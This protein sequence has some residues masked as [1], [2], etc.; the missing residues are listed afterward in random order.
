MKLT[1]LIENTCHPRYA[2]LGLQAEHGLSLL[3]EDSSGR[4]LLDTGATGAFLENARKLGVDLTRLDGVIL[5][6]NHYDHTGGI[7]ALLEHNPTV[8]I[9]LR[10]EAKRR[11]YRRRENAITYHGEPEE[12]FLRRPERF[13]FLTGE[14][15]LS[16]TVSVRVNRQLDQELF[17]RDRRRFCYLRQ[18]EYRDDDFA[19]EQFVVVEGERGLTIL[20]SCSHN[21]I[22]NILETVRRS[23]PGRPVANVV[24]GFHMMDHRLDSQGNRV[25]CMNCPDAFASRVAAALAEQVEGGIYTGHCTGP[26]ALRY[27]GRT[28]GARLHALSTGE[29]L[30]L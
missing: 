20:S 15:R 18:E 22:V 30:E 29:V 1:V 24:G 19:H 5:S 13:C 28:L 25:E 8:P 7:L 27:L 12:V 9:Y 16:P 2:R 3:L 10:E 11:L 23:Y 4:F 17:C 21:G 14:R 6:H 26:A